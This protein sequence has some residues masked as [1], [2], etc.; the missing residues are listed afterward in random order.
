MD[1]VRHADIIGGSIVGGLLLLF[2]GLS[3]WFCIRRKRRREQKLGSLRRP[4]PFDLFSEPS[5][6]VRSTSVE[7]RRTSTDA[8][9][10]TSQFNPVVNGPT[11]PGSPTCVADSSEPPTPAPFPNGD[12]K[13][14]TRRPRPRPITLSPPP[15]DEYQLAV[16]PPAH[17]PPSGV[18]VWPDSQLPPPYRMALH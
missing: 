14:R 5:G 6:H 13:H 1:Y 2:F 11:S 4:R 15:R 7:S 3:C 8:L 9:I 12:Q 16:P 17:S 10:P 18:M